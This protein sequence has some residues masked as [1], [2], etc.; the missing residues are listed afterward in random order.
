MGVDVERLVA[1]EQDVVREPSPAK[2]G[3]GFIAERSI[4]VD[5]GD[6][7]SERGGERMEGAGNIYIRSRTLHAAGAGGVR[8]MPRRTTGDSC[9]S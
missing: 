7:R 5:A 4:Q 9:A 1:E 3:R 2:L 6:F 8:I